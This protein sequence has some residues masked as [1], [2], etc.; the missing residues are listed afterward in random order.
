[1]AGLFDTRGRNQ[2]LTMM[3]EFGAWFA[4]YL[5]TDPAPPTR[6]SM[7]RLNPWTSVA[8]AIASSQWCLLSQLTN[9]SPTLPTC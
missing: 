5:E 8:P 6:D 4:K 2:S 3:T 7:T 9:V 1:M